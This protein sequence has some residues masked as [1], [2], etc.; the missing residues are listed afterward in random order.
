MF[1]F[2]C[3]CRP[4]TWLIHKF[5]IFISPPHACPVQNLAFSLR[6]K[7]VQ[8]TSCFKDGRSTLPEISRRAHTWSTSA[9]YVR[10]RWYLI[11]K[12]SASRIPFFRDGV[13]CCVPR[14]CALKSNSICFKV[15]MISSALRLSIA[16]FDL[17]T[18]SSYSLRYPAM[19][20]GILSKS[21][22]SLSICGR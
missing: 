8:G 19:M 6:K 16:R 2:R 14:H 15:S 1:C 3:N 10:A 18:E 22:V 5:G 11:Q 9:M 20:S 4:K 13:Q 21:I 17:I 7:M 12:F